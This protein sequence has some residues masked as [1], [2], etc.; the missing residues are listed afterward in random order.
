MNSKFT[1]AGVV[2]RLILFALLVAAGCYAVF[3]GSWGYAIPAFVLALVTA[4][5]LLYFV[6]STHRKLH[7]FFEAVKNEDGS[8]HFPEKT[9]D[10]HLRGLHEN[11]NRLNR[12]IS[13]IKVR[14]AHSERFFM[15]FMKRS[16]SGLIAVDPEG[17]VEIVND[18]ALR[19]IGLGNLTH[20]DR[21]E[22][23]NPSL[24]QLMQNLKPGQSESLKILQ[25]N[26]LQQVALKEARIRFSEKEYRI[27]SL[28][29]IK[30]EMEE[31]ELETWQKLIRIMTHEIMNSIAPIT[32]LSQTLSGFFEKEGSILKV[33]QLQQQEVDNTAEGLSVIRE[34]A[35]GLRSFVDNYRKLTR[36]PQPEFQPIHLQN[37]LNSIRLLFE[38][39]RKEQDIE[40]NI[41]NHHPKE[42]FLGDEKLLTHVVLNLLNNATE[43]LQGRTD[44]SITMTVSRTDAGALQLKVAD[45]GKGFREEERDKIFLPFY[46]T[47][48]NGSGIGLSLSRQIIRLHKGSISASSVFGVGSEFVVEV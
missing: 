18:A 3:S 19:L 33:E 47:R 20:L 2:W 40:F 4:W 30:T 16:A 11:M 14:Q 5:N 42:E 43:A 21:L 46:T 23:H 25:G 15:E 32:S 9:G 7:F 27:F 10:K 12:M 6:N 22:Q 35:E 34:R 38:S 36:L 37:W 39:Q 31:N 26:E 29:D 8:L 44:R 28:Y 45:N 48:E 41:L 17:F 1:Q 13:E 24:Y